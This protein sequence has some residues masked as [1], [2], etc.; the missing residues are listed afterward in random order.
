MNNAVGPIFNEKIDKKKIC[1]FVNS[2]QMYCSRKTVESCGYYLCTVHKQYHLLGKRCEKKK[3]NKKRINLKR[4]K[5][6][7]KLCLSEA[8]CVSH[9]EGENKEKTNLK[10]WKYKK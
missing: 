9:V 7:C 6:G 10:K 3:E 1:E 5:R 2:A 8:K 4:N